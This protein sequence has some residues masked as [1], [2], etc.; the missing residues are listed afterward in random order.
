LRGLPAEELLRR[1]FHEEKLRLFEPQ[2]L[3]FACVCSRER[4]A[5]MIHQ[6][7]ETEVRELLA[8]CGD[9]SV[10]CEFC[11][12]RYRFDAV[13]IERLFTDGDSNGPHDTLH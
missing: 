8:E 10:T 1:L 12:A 9:V 3:R 4:S 6:L 5:K 7:G 11:S 2:S 13:D